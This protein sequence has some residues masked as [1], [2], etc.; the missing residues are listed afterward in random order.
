MKNLTRKQKDY[1]YTKKGE[2]R[3]NV[4]RAQGVYYGKGLFRPVQTGHRGGRGT[5]RDVTSDVLGVIN[6]LGYKYKTGNDA[7]RGGKSGD[8]IKISSL[9]GD[10]IKKLK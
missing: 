6:I 10:R 2:L 7:P 3:S 4:K 9:A 8:F 1:L 5:V